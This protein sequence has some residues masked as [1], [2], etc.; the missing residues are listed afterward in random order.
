MSDLIDAHV[1]HLRSAGYALTT[2]R[3]RG[4]LLRRLN[5]QLA[6]GLDHCTTEELE[7]FLAAE[8]FS[9][10]TRWNYY[11]HVS[12]YFAWACEGSTIHLDY[13]PAAG[14]K[15]PRRPRA[16][17]PKPVT[18]EQLAHAV[19]SLAEP[20]LTYVRL[21]AFEGARCCEIAAVDRADITKDRTRLHGKGGKVRVLKTHPDVW[22]SVEHLPPGRIARRVSDGRPADPDYVSARTIERLKAIGLDGV[23]LHRFRHFFATTQLRSREFGGA[24][25]SIRVVQENLGHADPRTTAIYTAVSSEE[26]DASIAALPSFVA[27][28]PC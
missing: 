5:T 25:A 7:D 9:D 11:G 16:G 24:G 22:V 6:M 2:Y 23:T 14:L 3:D 19:T 27:P 15:R 1:R 10:E 21:A 8:H 20:W 13:N 4:E 26:R 28:D 17:V 12:G 18:T